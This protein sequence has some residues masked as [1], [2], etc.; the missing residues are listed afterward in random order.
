[1]YGCV[2]ALESVFTEG[3]EIHY[4]EHTDIVEDSL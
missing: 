2:I 1:M 4:N 3:A